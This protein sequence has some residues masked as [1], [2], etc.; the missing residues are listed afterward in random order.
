MKCCSGTG[1]GIDQNHRSIWV[2]VWDQNQNSDFGPIIV[3]GQARPKPSH[4]SFRMTP[5]ML[6]TEI[7]KELFG[8]YDSAQLPR[9]RMQS[10]LGCANKDLRLI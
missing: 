5:I 8:R 1:N 4:N 2:S 10:I 9:S 7:T 3:G 6:H